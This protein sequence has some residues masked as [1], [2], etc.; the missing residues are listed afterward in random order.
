MSSIAD[1]CVVSIS[2]TDTSWSPTR[3]LSAKTE[4]SLMACTKG[5]PPTG[6]SM[7]TPNFPAGASTSIRSSCSQ[8]CCSKEAS[9]WKRNASILAAI[10][11][12]QWKECPCQTRYLEIDRPRRTWACLRSCLCPDRTESSSVFVVSGHDADT[13]V[14]GI[15]D[16][17]TCSKHCA[18]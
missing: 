14:G 18:T 5:T 1:N 17:R 9:S 7:T 10:H 15:L 13:V 16:E 3:T 11:R 12:L 8:Y 6:V 4:V 2:S